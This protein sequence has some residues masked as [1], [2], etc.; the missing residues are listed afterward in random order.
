[1]RIYPPFRSTY[2]CAS[3]F[4]LLFCQSLVAQTTI[5][6]P[7]KNGTAPDRIMFEFA[8]IHSASFPDLLNINQ[9]QALAKQK[10][11]Q[12]VNNKNES[13]SQAESF[14]VM[15]SQYLGL[16]EDKQADFKRKI[17]CAKAILQNLPIQEKMGNTRFPISAQD[18]V[19]IRQ[20]FQK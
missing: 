8:T 15:R 10:V 2:W 19:F 6:Q 20:L 14:I 1:M 5:H 4:V 11:Q 17:E 7:S 3:L 18:M 16:A 13:V 12:W 9:D